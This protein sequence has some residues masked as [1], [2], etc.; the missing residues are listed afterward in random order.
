MYITI[1]RTRFESISGPINLPYGTD[2]NS[3]GDFLALDNAPI[4]A[5]TSQ[6]AYDYFARNDDGKGLERG[7]LTQAIR[8]ALEKRD[9]DYQARWDRVWEDKLCQKYKRKEHADHWLWNHD[10]YNAEIPD[11]Q[12]I[13]EL[14]GAKG[15]V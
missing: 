14:V 12:Y 8:A 15:G 5:V 10:F 13:A 3:T 11:L 4:C 2:V 7:R 9:K 6:N 1:K